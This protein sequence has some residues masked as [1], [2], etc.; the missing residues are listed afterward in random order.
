[1]IF[2]KKHAAEQGTILAMCDEELLGKVLSQGKLCI[3]LE[4]YADFYRGELISE[5]RA[6]G[7][8]DDEEIYSANVVGERSVAV[9]MNKGL[10]GKGEVKKVGKV[11]FVQIFKVDVF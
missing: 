11:P 4:K 3:D 8:V 1:M 5:Q 9:M 2:L 7:M 10:V 6:S